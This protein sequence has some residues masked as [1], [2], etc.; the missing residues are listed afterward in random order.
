MEL[1]HHRAGSGEPLV[2]IHGV[3]SQWQ[4]WAPVLEAVSRERDVIAVDLPGFG[5]SPTLPIGVVPSA[6]AL[7]DAVA[8]FLDG[9]GIEKPV[10]GGNSLGGWI[11]LELAARGRAKA[12]VGVSPAGF[13]AP[14]ESAAARA[15]LVASAQGAR[16]MPGLTEWL[17]RR[18]R[19]RLV[20]F[21]GLMGVPA[22][23][24]AGAALSATR[25]LARSPGFDATIAVIT[26]DRFTRASEVGVPVALLWG[27]KDYVLFPWQ[28]RRA[29]RE[30]P[31]ARHVPLYGAGHVPMWDDPATITR[32][33]LAA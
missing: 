30:L 33:L 7:A 13:A 6:R 2:L 27:T 14:W 12:V 20:A 15:H 19:G 26:R 17:L 28:V 23:L 3:G 24:P 9:I 5:D 32:E 22:R 31:R 25:N 18:P 16:R 1:N 10:I 4:V 8:A 29:L 11:A 21:G